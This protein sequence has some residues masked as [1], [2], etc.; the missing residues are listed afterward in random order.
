MILVDTHVHVTP[1]DIIAN[2]EK[3]TTNE[4]HFSL[5]SNTKNN[6]FAT[7]EDVIISMEKNGIEK[8][9][10]FGFAFNDLGLCRYVNDYVIEK[11]KQFPDKLTGFAVVPPCEGA[12]QEIN[13][14]YNAGLVGVGELFP[15]FNE[16]EN[17]H[18]ICET[19]KEL[20]LP[21]LLHVNEGVGHYYPG[22]T[23]VSLKQLENFITNNPKLKIILAHFGGGLFFY[24]LMKELKEKFCNVYYDTAAA[25]FLYDK[26][27][28]KVIKTLDLCDKIIF[29]SDFPLLQP[30]RYFSDI[31]ESGFTEEEKEKILGGNIKN[32]LINI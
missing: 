13:R 7:A 31:E 5:L 9:V 6:K 29:G 22:K 16:S 30:S 19:C 11:V 26:K 20:N 17:W 15:K 2:W 32:I 27:I 12:A 10:I 4:P 18:E 24:E 28:Y 21:I 3:Y 23:D 14:C 1:P 8:S 25:P